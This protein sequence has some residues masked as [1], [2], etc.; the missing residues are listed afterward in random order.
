MARG[1]QTALLVPAKPQQPPRERLKAEVRVSVIE[2][3]ASY[4]KCFRAETGA[5]ITQ[6]ELVDYIL[7]KFLQRDKV[8]Q[9]WAK[10]EN[11]VVKFD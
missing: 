5:D 10:T 9:A 4:Q 1:K 11:L 8:F 6:D 3:L 2:G 7:T